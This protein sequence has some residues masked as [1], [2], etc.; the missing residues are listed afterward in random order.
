MKRESN[1]KKKDKEEEPWAEYYTEPSAPIFRKL[2]YDSVESA[3]SYK[4]GWSPSLSLS[5]DAF[6][7]NFQA[8]YIKWS[9]LW[10]NTR[11]PL[12]ETAP[13]GRLEHCCIIEVD[14]ESIE[15]TV[16]ETKKTF[17]AV[18]LKAR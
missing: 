12:S 4:Q 9:E 3:N 17:H 1:K 5:T 10:P 15:E 8:T 16:V 6:F 11:I 18:N 13:E 2:P 7:R 14:L